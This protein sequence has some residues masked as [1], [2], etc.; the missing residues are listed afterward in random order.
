[1]ALLSNFAGQITNQACDHE[2]VYAQ[3]AFVENIAGRFHQ[4]LMKECAQCG[5]MKRSRFEP[6]PKKKEAEVADKRAIQ[7][8]PETCDHDWA[9]MQLVNIIGDQQIYTTR[10]QCERCSVT[11]EEI[12]MSEEEMLRAAHEPVVQ[13]SEEVE[14]KIDVEDAC[15]YCGSEPKLPLQC[16]KCLVWH[17]AEC[18][19]SFGSCTV[20]GCGAQLYEYLLSP[21]AKKA[22]ETIKALH[23]VALAVGVSEGDDTVDKDKENLGSSELNELLSKADFEALTLQVSKLT[24]ANEKGREIIH[25][26]RDEVER[27]IRNYERD[28][29]P[30][31]ETAIAVSMA[32]F[33]VFFFLL[34]WGAMT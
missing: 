4:V 9:T 21:E 34:L 14:L 28:Q 2:W 29:Q 10:R 3:P 17:C 26:Y 19:F 5:V 8:K 22:R 33:G 24:A 27:I 7:V 23:N 30:T 1:M 13:P 16:S 12:F 11:Y 15:P 31:P 20:Y 6:K 32:I 18:W 25:S